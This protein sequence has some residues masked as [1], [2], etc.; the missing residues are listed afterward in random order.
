MPRRMRLMISMACSL[1]MPIIREILSL[2]ESGDSAMMLLVS[3]LSL[4]FLVE[5]LFDLSNIIIIRVV[6]NDADWEWLHTVQ[7]SHVVREVR[8]EHLRTVSIHSLLA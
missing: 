3:I 1:L 5:F 4:A 8:V 6:F 2:I 7:V